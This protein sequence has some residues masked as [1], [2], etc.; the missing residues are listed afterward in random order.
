MPYSTQESYVATGGQ[1]CPCCNS[2]DISGG[3]VEINEGKAFQK[4]NCGDCGA[5][6]VDEYALTG[7]QLV[8]EPT[9]TNVDE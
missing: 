7:Y 5:G 3:F 9:N 2:S 6:W 4:V 8:D 1:N